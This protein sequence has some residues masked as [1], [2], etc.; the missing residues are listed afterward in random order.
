M[1]RVVPQAIMRAPA[2]LCL[3]VLIATTTL[4]AQD[5]VTPPTSLNHALPAD[6]TG[7]QIFRTACATCH[8]TDGRGSPSS[9]VGFELPLPNGH[10]FPDFTDCPTNTVE[11]LGDWMA[12]AHRGGP[13]RGLDRHMPAFGDALTA[14]QIERAVRYL[15]TFCDDSSWPRGDLNLPRAFF[16]EKAFPENE[17]VWTTAVTTS[18]TKAVSNQ[19]VYE[20]RIGSRAQY[21][22]TVPF[23]L[24]QADAGGAWSRG[25]GDVEVA[26]RRTFY[27]SYPRGSI[28]AA[29]GAVTLPTG[30][31]E[32]GLGN[33]YT[34]FE[35][36]AMWGQIIG[37]SGFLQV[38]SGVEIPSD[39]T[40]GSN[41]G[42]LRTAFGYTIASDQG[43][44]RA[45][46]PMAEVIVAK[47]EGAPAEWDVVP[48]MQVSLSK[49]QHI[50]LSVGVRVP[51]N[52]REERKP[53]FLTYFLWDWFDGGLFQFWR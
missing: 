45:W 12:V 4:R 47:P 19:I 7:E 16:T 28:F 51:L 3:G 17:V 24:Q 50:L 40:R 26:L 38:H 32:I 30:K 34:I 6:A 44:G 22:V 29:G 13:I 31:E 37:A 33:G 20:H 39:H 21:E 46:S 36:F 5:E 53:Q 35:P 25:L 23:D 49:L 15:W 48:Q 27:A 10:T 42:F 1:H 2:A 41:E 18:G 43:F 11:P 52:E 9:V 14:D 8:A